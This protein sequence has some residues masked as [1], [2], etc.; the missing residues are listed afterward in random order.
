M[1]E[2]IVSTLPGAAFQTGVRT[3]LV[4]T[5]RGPQGRPGDMG[6]PGDP[7]SGITTVGQWSSGVTYGPNDAV[8]APSSTLDGVINLFI[9]RANV[10]SSVSTVP[11]GD[12]PARWVETGTVGFGGS[13]GNIWEVV[14]F[15]HGI[16][17]VG[18]PVYWDAPTGLYR[19]AQASPFTDLPVAVVR[20]IPDVNTLILQSS[21]L[22]PFVDPA[23]VEVGGWIDGTVYFQ[24]QNGLIGTA[25]PA[26]GY[27]VMAYL[28]VEDGAIV[29]PYQNAFDMVPTPDPAPV[30]ATTQI[31]VDDIS[32][33]FDGIE[34][35]FAITVSAAPL[36]LAPAES[37]E[38]YI[39]GHRQEPL[40]DYAIT[41]NAGNSVLTF[42]APPEDYQSF[43]CV[44]AAA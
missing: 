11:P 41:D 32:S 25:P 42:T 39:D 33:A 1:T 26:T 7:G 18:T 8:T 43:W 9:Q 20:E 12:D 37:F 10:P 2:I 36:T 6:P 22:I 4:S 17:R 35:S 3:V 16:T 31:K 34:T 23:L 15:T 5:S 44:Y 14:Q 24:R 19:R 28:A 29:F 30:A 38:V 27:V 40:I 21:G 13:T